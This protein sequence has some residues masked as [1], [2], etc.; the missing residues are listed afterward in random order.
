[1]LSQSALS[2]RVARQPVAGQLAP[3]EPVSSDLP[4]M[5]E[6]VATVEQRYD[7][8]G[9]WVAI[10]VTFGWYLAGVAPVVVDVW[11][12]YGL[13]ASGAVTWLLF[14]VRSRP[15]AGTQVHLEWARA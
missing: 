8:V 2:T 14:A 13:N 10:V 9:L 15:G 3:S 7:R 1:M 11:L 12:R 6:S 5:T 4:A